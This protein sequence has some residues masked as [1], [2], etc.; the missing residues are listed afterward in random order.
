MTIIELSFNSNGIL[1]GLSGNPE[2]S[3][4]AFLSLTSALNDVLKNPFN[5]TDQFTGLIMVII[6]KGQKLLGVERV[7]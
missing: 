7:N 2:S 3:S 6:R 4:L 5:T 1:D